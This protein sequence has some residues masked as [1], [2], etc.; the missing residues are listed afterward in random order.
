[1]EINTDNMCSRCGV[2]TTHKM[3]NGEYICTGDNSCYE[4]LQQAINEV[5]EKLEEVWSKK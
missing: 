2:K 3:V 5:S 4:L 1:M